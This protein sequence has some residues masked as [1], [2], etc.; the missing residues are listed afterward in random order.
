[1]AVTMTHDSFKHVVDVSATVGSGGWFIAWLTNDLQPIVATLA[2]LAIL[3]FW[4]VRLLI[5]FRK[6]RD[7]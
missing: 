1:M 5:E 6:Y 2:G 7:G 3:A 4:V